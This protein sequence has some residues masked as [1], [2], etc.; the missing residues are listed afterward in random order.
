MSVLMGTITHGKLVAD[1]Y[2]DGTVVIRPGLESP[3]RLLIH[4]DDLALMFGLVEKV[5]DTWLAN[6]ERKL[7]SEP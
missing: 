1:L 2:E 5:Q 4:V 6:Y 7:R 3:I